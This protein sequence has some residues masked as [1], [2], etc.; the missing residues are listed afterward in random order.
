MPKLLLSP[1]GPQG[2]GV[3]EENGCQ[4]FFTNG[5]IH[6]S[7]GQRPGIGDRPPVP[8]QRPWLPRCPESTRDF[9]T[10]GGG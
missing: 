7:L 2:F 9:Q 8:A 10:V 5:E 1:L 4:S 3:G 6:P